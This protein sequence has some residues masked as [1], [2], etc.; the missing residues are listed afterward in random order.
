MCL[1]FLLLFIQSLKIHVCQVV[2][3]NKVLLTKRG[4][5]KLCGQKYCCFLSNVINKMKA[6]CKLCLRPYASELPVLVTTK[7]ARQGR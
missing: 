1:L 7:A 6:I 4:K 5:F 3:T 2:V